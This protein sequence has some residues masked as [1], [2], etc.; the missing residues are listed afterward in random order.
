MPAVT[1]LIYLRKLLSKTN[2]EWAGKNSGNK[3]APKGNRKR[4]RKYVNIYI[5]AFLP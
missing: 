2:K 4:M 3:M 1:L 5:Y